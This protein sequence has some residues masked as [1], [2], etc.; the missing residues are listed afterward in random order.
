MLKRSEVAWVRGET[1]DFIGP[2]FM[3]GPVY[4]RA[5]RPSA[6]AHAERLFDEGLVE[7]LHEIGFLNH[8]TRSTLEIEGSPFTI[9][10]DS[11]TFRFSANFFTFELLKRAA[12][13]WV[14]ANILLHAHGLG[15]IDGHLGNFALFGNSDPRW[16]DLGSIVPLPPEPNAKYG[17]TEF[18]RFF[19]GP[20]LTVAKH[21]ALR[22]IIRSHAL[23]ADIGLQAAE[24]EYLTGFRLQEYGSDRLRLLHAMRDALA[25]ADF[26]WPETTW[27]HY[28]VERIGRVSSAG[29]ANASGETREGSVLSTLRAELRPEDLVLDLGANDGYF[30]LHAAAAGARAIISD[31]DE[32]AL[33]RG[34]TRVDREPDWKAAFV[35]GE[36]MKNVHQADIV[37]ALALTHHL[38]LGQNRYFE[39]IAKKLASYTRRTLITEFMPWGLSVKG[40]PANLPQDYTLDKFVAWFKTFFASVEV[41][42][43]NVAEAGHPRVLVVC[44]K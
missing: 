37:L 6:R 36:S 22:S 10:S 43:H 12:L 17:I 33:A 1:A 5:V 9:A 39:V 11:A 3:R 15:L 32:E 40:E 4:Y 23:V 28:S 7:T 31:S 19:L 24:S 18:V 8:Q 34:L 26:R 13:K 27:S 16:Y 29:L 21:P 38:R 30:G 14:D 20:I 35:A 25:S 41:I 44:R 42:A 2:V